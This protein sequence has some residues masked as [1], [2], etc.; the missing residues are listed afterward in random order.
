M[1]VILDVNVWISALLWG[2]IPARILR[3]AHQGKIIIFISD[4]IMLELEM[5]LKRDKFK[6]RIE[7]RGY[8]IEYLL[9]VVKEISYYC[10]TIALDVQ[11]LRDPKDTIIL[12]AS[13]TAQAQA[14]ITGDLDL[15]VLVKFNHIPILNPQTFLELYFTD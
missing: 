10:S 8:S 3:L 13:I 9:N 7:T 4:E 5:T 14:I 6:G 12:S 2:G 11:E 1:N 15:L